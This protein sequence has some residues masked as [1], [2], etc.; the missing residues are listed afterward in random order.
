MPRDNRYAAL[1]SVVLGAGVLAA[2]AARAETINACNNTPAAIPDDATTLI[3]PITVAGGGTVTDIT[4]D[5]D[6]TH[7]WIGDL[8]VTL[9]DGTTSVDLMSRVALGTYPFGCGGDDVAATFSDA[10]TTTPADLCS[11]TTVPNITGLVRP[12]GSLSAFAGTAADSPWE[13]QITD[14]GVFDAGTINSVCLTLTT[15]PPPGCVG[16]LDGDSDTDVFD[17]GIFAATFG[18]SVPPGTGA[19]FDGSGFVDVFDFGIFASDFGCT[20]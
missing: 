11:P 18:L 6:I 2:S 8:V 7:P 17:F 19:D 4:V 16:D 1:R 20:P 3:V 14:E 12:A 9:T 13:L 5:L 10:A 15:T